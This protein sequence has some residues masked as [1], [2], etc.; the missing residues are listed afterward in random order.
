M[1]SSNYANIAMTLNGELDTEKKFY[2]DAV[3]RSSIGEQSADSELVF[4]QAR[5]QELKTQIKEY[6]ALSSTSEQKEKDESDAKENKTLQKKEQDRIAEQNNNGLMF[7]DDDNSKSSKNQALVAGAQLTSNAT[8][9]VV[10]K[11]QQHSNDVKQDDKPIS[12]SGQA[13][14]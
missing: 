2:N 7:L 5:V 11:V 4:I 6:E 9:Q 3:R 10:G 1:D 12:S 14:T 13:S 8:A